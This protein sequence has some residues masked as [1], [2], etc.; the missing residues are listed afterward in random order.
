MVYRNLIAGSLGSLELLVGIAAL[1]GGGSLIADP[2]GARLQMPISF[3]DSTPFRSYLI[4]GGLLFGV[5]GLSNVFAGYLALRR[6]R[7]AGDFGNLRRGDPRR[8]DGSPDLSGWIPASDSIDLL[9]HRLRDHRRC[10][11]FRGPALGGSSTLQTQVASN[12]TS[13]LTVNQQGAKMQ[14][15]QKV[16]EVI[17]CSAEDAVEAES[18]GA[19][20]IELVRAL[21]MGGFTPDLMI[22]QQVAAAVNIPVRVMIR[23]SDASTAYSAEEFRLIEDRLRRIS[24]L[25][26]EGIVVGFVRRGVIETD[27]LERI[28]KIVP[29]WRITFHRAFEQVNDTKEAFRTL[30][31]FPQVDRVLTRGCEGDGATRRRCLEER[32]AEAGPEITIIAAGGPEEKTLRLLGESQ[33]IREVHVGRAARTPAVHNGL[34]RRARV[35]AVREI[36]DLAIH[37]KVG[38]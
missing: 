21:A 12:R 25:P 23:E 7:F 3:L 20:R 27:K 26:L 35:A 17:A 34:V 36:L 1:F 14:Q 16:L 18:G 4:P 13:L 2:S 30:K 11:G 15:V 28:I 19:N 32:Q 33:I 22:V 37:P 6:K 31:Q 24:E 9:L 38:P 29:T 10:S 5:V 8:A